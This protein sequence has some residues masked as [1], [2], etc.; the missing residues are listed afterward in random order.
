MSKRD[1]KI[2]LQELTKEQLEEQVLDLYTR[3]KPVK[4][5][6]N[7]VFKPNEE[8][9]LDEAKFKIGKEYF[10][11]NGRK[12][13]A[14]RSIAQKIIKHFIQLG[15]EPFVVADVM[16]FNIE[17]ALQYNE[18]KLIK[19][20]AFYKSILRSFEDAVDFINEHGIM[21]DFTTRISSLLKGVK[22][23]EWYNFEGFERS[24]NN[25]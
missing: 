6:Y 24:L 7:F 25:F 15:V 8:K 23:Q 20:E 22:S 4:T 2:Y 19:Q 17:V 10:P 12:P 3:F 16:L 18:D 13:K 9:L 14:R 11:V 21:A 5:Y 1:L